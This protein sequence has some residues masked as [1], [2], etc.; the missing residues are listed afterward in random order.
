MVYR[1]LWALSFNFNDYNM[2]IIPF[3]CPLQCLQGHKY[4]FCRKSLENVWEKAF[5]YPSPPIFFLTKNPVWLK[6]ASHSTSFI[7]KSSRFLLIFCSKSIYNTAL[8]S[9]L[10]DT[11]MLNEGSQRIRFYNWNVFAL[12]SATKIHL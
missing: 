10:N 8:Q 2:M 1:Q 9:K 3:K 11:V 4:S 12:N 5:V 6:K 7:T